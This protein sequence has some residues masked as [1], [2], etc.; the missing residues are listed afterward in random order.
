MRF[1]SCSRVLL[2]AYP[3]AGFAVWDCSSL[4]SWCEILNLRSLDDALGSNLAKRFPHGVGEV[5][6]ASVLQA[7]TPSLN[8]DDPYRD[9]RPLLSILTHRDSATTSSLLLYSLRT[10]QLVNVVDISGTGHR[11]LSNKRFIVI[12]TTSP[13]ALHVLSALAFLPTPFSPLTD[14][15]PSP[16]DGAPV[17]DLGQGGRLL[18][19]AT[20]RIVP[21]SLHDREAA[22]PGAGIVAQQGMFDGDQH[23][24]SF[25]QLS[26]RQSG[27]VGDGRTAGQVGGDVA[28]RAAGGVMSGVKA[29]GGLGMSYL[30]Q[31]S[32]SNVADGSADVGRR[33]LSKSAPLPSFLGFE[34]TPPINT[35]RTSMTQSRT[36][37]AD[38]AFAGTLLI[39]DL[40]SFSLG[41]P[42][43][44]SRR[45]ALSS[46]PIL[47]TLAHFRP[48]LH[49][50]ALVS[51]SPSSSFVLTSTS[52][53][54][55]F[56]V[57]ELK[58][59]VN[60]GDVPT[61][62]VWHRYRLARGYSSAKADAA[63]WSPDSR[64]VAVATGKG[65]TR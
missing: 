46:S 45:K 17:F 24:H 63:S 39:V 36:S 60:P 1:P 26:P 16:F 23:G 57:F 7:P 52:Q 53:G 47:N 55:A 62:K 64:F 22:R 41:L 21:V 40:L 4:D 28:R 50:I 34:R 61:G 8:S 51:L 30:Q 6:G 42:A 32:A 2:L 15:A 59:T 27:F 49:A 19:Y 20:D 3:S 25:E 56:D 33:R 12:S 31:R 43:N 18:A 11:I 9:A 37:G 13:R 44:S 65:T 35:P 38:A 48:S 14:V 29:L 58:P 5:V 10:H 54:H